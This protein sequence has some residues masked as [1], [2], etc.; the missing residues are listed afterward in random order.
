MAYRNGTYVA[1]DGQ[2]TTDP[3][4]SDMK[5]YGLLQRWNQ[6]KSNT[7]SFSDSHKKTHQVRD[8]SSKLTLQR[9]LIERLGNSK[10][11]LLILS[12][13]TSWDRGMLNFEIEKAVDKFSLPIIVAYTGYNYILDP[14]SFSS[15]WPKEL[16]ARISNGT[17]RCIHIPFKEKAIMSAISQ[18]SIHGTGDNILT[19]S[20]NY[21]S[22]SAYQNW[23]Y[24]Q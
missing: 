20:L 4:K 15:K 8:T 21:Y 14:K 5:Y 17:A 1:F 18:F 24:I 11:M 19:G 6:N 23:G 12:D 16:T 13:D 22:R 7:L 10:N 2:A 9:R 3:T